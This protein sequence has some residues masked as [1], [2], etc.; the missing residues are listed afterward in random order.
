MT[1]LTVTFPADEL[2][3]LAELPV[4]IGIVHDDINEA[5]EQ[6]FVVHLEVLDA[7]DFDLLQNTR[8]TSFCAIID[9]DG[10]YVCT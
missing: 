8:N 3:P 4:D 7:M 9:N 6:I 5:D 1:V 10:M 2:S